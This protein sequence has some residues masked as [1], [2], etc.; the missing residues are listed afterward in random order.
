MIYWLIAHPEQTI[1]RAS[2]VYQFAWG[3]W[4]YLIVMRIL[5]WK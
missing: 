1:Y 3:F 2:V 4:V 5:G